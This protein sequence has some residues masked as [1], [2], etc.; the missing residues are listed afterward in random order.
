MENYNENW[1]GGGP[2]QYGPQDYGQGAGQYGS[3]DYGQGAGQYGSQNYGQG[4]G[5]YGS[6]DYGQGAGQYGSQDYGQGAGQYGSQGCGQGAGQYGS[7]GCGQGTGQYGNLNYGG[8]QYGGYGQNQYG[9]QTYGPT[10]AQSALKSCGKSGCFIA[11]AV[12]FTLS[13]LLSVYQLFTGQSGITGTINGEVSHTFT[14][15]IGLILQVPSVLICIGM[16]R[17]LAGSQGDGMPAAGAFSMI[18]G[19][20]IALLVLVSILGAIVVIVLAAALSQASAYGLYSSRAFLNW[21]DSDIYAMRLALPVLLVIFLTVFILAVVYCVKVIGTAGAA[22]QIC[23]TGWPNKKLSMY[24]VVINFI[25]I[26]L[27]ALSMAAAQPMAGKL[28]ARVNIFG[29]VGSLASIAVMLFA[30]INIL[31]LRGKLMNGR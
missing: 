17:I 25:M 7:Q 18:R 16:W 12:V 11:L 21:Y 3:Q 28:G 27:M 1:N 23:R 13:V 22:A 24:V 5:Q 20:M 9:G 4:A 31:S 2:D 30:N 14:I 26:V 29:M 10:Q 6:Q 19:A 15:I 8:N